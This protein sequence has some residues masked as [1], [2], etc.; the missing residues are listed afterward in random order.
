MVQIKMWLPGVIPEIL[1]EQVQGGMGKLRF[2]GTTGDSDQTT[3]MTDRDDRSTS[4]V[5]TK[6]CKVL[7]VNSLSSIAECV[8]QF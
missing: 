5:A 1:I 4:S 2:R 3:N 6:R 8:P 7:P